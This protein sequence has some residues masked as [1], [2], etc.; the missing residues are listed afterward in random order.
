MWHHSDTLSG[1]RVNQSLLVSLIL[2]A[3]RKNNKYKSYICVTNDNGYV[4]L[5]VNT[6]PFFPRS[7]LFTGFVTRLTRRLPLVEPK[8]HTLPEHMNS[9]AVFRGVR[10]TRFLVLWCMFCRSLFVLLYIFFLAIVFC[11]SL[12]V[13]LYIFCWPLCCLLFF[14][15]RILLTP[16][17]SSNSSYIIWFDTI[18]LEPTIYTTDVVH[19]R[20]KVRL[21]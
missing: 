3:K 1:F 9:P 7:W 21:S 11:K 12:F 18:G 14:D 8:L 15:I 5:V 10:F 13:L 2:R 20:C 16:L 6:S 17:V 4:S 19:M